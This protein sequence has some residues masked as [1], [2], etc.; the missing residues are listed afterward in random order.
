VAVKCVAKSKLSTQPTDFLQEID[1]L[2]TVDHP[3][4]VQLFGVASSN[5]SFMLVSSLV[6]PAVLVFHSV[7][8]CLHPVILALLCICFMLSAS[9]LSSVY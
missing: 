4:V 7:I 5:D 2:S 8:P 9:L 3:H 1:A 6:I